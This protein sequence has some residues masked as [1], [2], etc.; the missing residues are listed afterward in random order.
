MKVPAGQ[1]LHELALAPLYFPEPQIIQSDTELWCTAAEA[2][3][4]KKVPLG[5]FVH[6]TEPTADH[7]PEEQ[8]EQEP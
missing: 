6:D 1:L 4:A 8:T 7:F 2:G 3:S 5:Q